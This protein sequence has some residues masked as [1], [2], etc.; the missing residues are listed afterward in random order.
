[1]YYTESRVDITK[2]VKNGRTQIVEGTGIESEHK[3]REIAKQKGSYFFDVYEDCEKT[4]RRVH[5]SYGIP[6]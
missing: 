5:T 1:M 4:K 2:R 6:K 3:A